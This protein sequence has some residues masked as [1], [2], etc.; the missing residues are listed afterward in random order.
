MWSALWTW[1]LTAAS[2]E[3]RGGYLIQ[4]DTSVETAWV[5]QQGDHAYLTTA[6]FTTKLKKILHTRQTLPSPAWS[7][8]KHGDR[9][10]VGTDLGVL[11]L[12]ADR[13]VIR[14]SS[15]RPDYLR[16]WHIRSPDQ[17]RAQLAAEPDSYDISRV[18]HVSTFRDLLLVGTKTYGDWPDGE[19]FLLDTKPGPDV[20]VGGF[21][22]KAVHGLR[23]VAVLGRGLVALASTPPRGEQC[24][25]GD[26]CDKD[27]LRVFNLSSFIEHHLEFGRFMVNRLLMKT[28]RLA[29]AH[30]CRV[31][32]LAG[33]E[34]HDDVVVACG[35]KVLWFRLIA[36]EL[37]LVAQAS[38][39]REHELLSM[40][41][42]EYPRVA[43]GAKQGQLFVV[44]LQRTDTLEVNG[45]THRGCRDQATCDVVSVL[46]AKDYS[47]LQRVT[48][49]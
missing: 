35:W 46:R 9:I 15:L 17:M 32:A 44:S 49:T 22:S 27:Y 5:W 16:E 11:E 19:L 41:A 4:H 23:H 12:V 21:G 47:R 26:T 18:L 6:N 40:T 1:L 43:V 42:M 38:F 31:A 33:F 14:S 25:L 30:V 48:G 37:K 24:W 7:V 13:T 28:F 34:D 2:P 8:T 10:M 39:L 29:E 3:L 36:T 45:F 20:T